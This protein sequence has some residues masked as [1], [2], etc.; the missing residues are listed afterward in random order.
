[1]IHNAHV[2]QTPRIDKSD[3]RADVLVDCIRNSSSPQVQQQA[4]LLVSILASTV[5]DLVIHNVMPIFTFMNSGIMK[6]TDD[7]SAHI[8]KQVGDRLETIII[9]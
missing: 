2:S 4:L 8:V 9:Y 6:R 3:V 5:P 7:Y 1:M